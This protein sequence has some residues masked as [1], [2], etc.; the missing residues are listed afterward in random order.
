MS[1]EGE[2]ARV[3]GE[4]SRPEPTLPTVNPAVEKSEPPKPTFHPAVYVR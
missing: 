4:V 1:N 3:S 2:K